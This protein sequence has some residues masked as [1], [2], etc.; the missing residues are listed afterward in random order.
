MTRQHLRQFVAAEHAVVEA[1]IAG[2]APHLLHHFPALREFGLSEAELQSAV[3]FEPDR[4]PGAL[5]QCGGQRRPFRGGGAG[6]ALVM[7]RS[8][9]LALH[10]DEP[11]IAARGAI[12]DIALVDQRDLEP[13]RPSP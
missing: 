1:E 4:D 9:P 2:L 5:L 3:L 7:R 13:V 10:P 11:E 8:Q 12:G 6:P